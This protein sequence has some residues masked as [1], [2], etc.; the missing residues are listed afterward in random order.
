MT[1]L[2]WF[3]H[4]LRLQ[5]NPALS[6]AGELSAAGEAKG[7]VAV[8]I[9]C[10][11]YAK[12]HH[13]AA[14]QLEF[15]RQHLHLLV[16]DL[17]K[18]AIPL[19]VVSVKKAKDIPQSLLA[20][21]EKVKATHCLFNAEYPVNELN[22][23]RAVY[24]LLHAQRIKVIRCHDRCLIPPGDIRNG[25]GEPYKVFTAFKKKWLDAAKNIHLTH[26]LLPKKQQWDLP[27]QS[28]T[29][30][31]IDQLFAPHRLRDLSVYWP[32]GEKEADHR[33]RCFV[34]S[35]LTDYKDQ[36]DFPSVEGTSTLSPYF[37]VGSLSV[38]Q[39]LMAVLSYTHGEWESQNA[40]ANCWIS[41]LIW[42]EFY[43]HIL[44]DFPYVCKNKPMQANTEFFPWSY[45]KK[46]FSAWCEGR[47]GI[48]IVDAAMRQLNTTGWMHNRLRMVVAMFLTKNCQVDWRWGEHY[49]MSQ[50]IDGDFA[51]NNGGWQWSA[52]TG[53][54]AAP[55]FRIFNPISQSERFDPDGVFIRNWI[56]ELK[57]VSN[58]DIH[59]PKNSKENSVALMYPESIVDLS[60]SRK[61][62][63]NL[64]A[65]LP[66]L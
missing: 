19:L 51:A 6:K 16:K 25:Q 54:D 10:I 61:S 3:R 20:L 60:E 52:S 14:C 53:T 5:D 4:D 49:F 55:Y 56:P 11:D 8:Y 63:I 21:A 62:T 12:L 7:I 32:A 37:A 39:A 2:V 24:E 44:V 26:L 50:L 46:I 31:E 41:E 28:T 40:G 58:K 34:E 23:D 43:Q 57:S 45:D 48:P 17:T 30:Q 1:A 65:Q 15:I 64:F 13:T 66:K 33:L 27:I 59:Y 35:G 38:R 9:D 18:L 36:R 29:T 47:T 22:R 42:R